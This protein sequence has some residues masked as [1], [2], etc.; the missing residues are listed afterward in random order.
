[1]ARLIKRTAAAALREL[2][3][4]FP[5]V[6]VTGPR[7]A[8]KTTLVKITFPGKPY[9][10][11]EDPDVREFAD[12]DPRGFLGQFPAGAILDEVQR[13]PKLLSYLQGIVDERAEM[14]MSS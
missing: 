1:M 4:G 13:C 3:Q 10:S 7:Q 12:G 5:I 14:G 9:A 11:L 6:V 8:G 2:A